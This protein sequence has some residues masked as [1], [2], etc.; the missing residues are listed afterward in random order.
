MKA[1]DSSDRVGPLSTAYRWVDINMTAQDNDD[2][3]DKRRNILPSRIYPPV[4][5][6]VRFPFSL[7]F[8]AGLVNKTHDNGN[9]CDQ[10]MNAQTSRMRPPVKVLLNV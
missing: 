4:G 1:Q 5:I 7:K 3:H 10:P 6:E 9:L 2:H 8:H